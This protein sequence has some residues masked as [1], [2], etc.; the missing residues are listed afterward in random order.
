M[1]RSNEWNAF[2]NQ[3]GNYVDVELVDLP[4]VEKRS[5]QLSAAHHP[6]VFSWFC[7][8]TLR[9]SFRRLRNK[10][11]AW[12]RRAFRRLPRKNVVG[13]L[14]VKHP[15]FAFLFLVIVEK[16]VVGL[17]SPQDGVDC[18]IE[19]VHAVVDGVRSAI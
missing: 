16:P 2:T 14:G 12:W 13:Y 17:A 7:A 11:Y 6:D 9:K 8:Q 15:A 1:A 3:R 5:D 19:L 10:F 18:P 4:G